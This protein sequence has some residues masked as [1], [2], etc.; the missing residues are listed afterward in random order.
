MTGKRLLIIVTACA[1]LAAGVAVAALPARGSDQDSVTQ[2]ALAKTGSIDCF[3]TFASGTGGSYFAWCYSTYGNIVR[4]ESPAGVE[5]IRV[6]T[7][8]EGYAVCANGGT[9]GWD[10]GNSGGGFNA[11][12]YPAANTVQL[13]TTNGHFRLN[14]TFSQSTK[15]KSVT[16]AMRLTNLTSST[17]SGV[18]L[19]R[20]ADLDINGTPASDR[21]D[22]SRASV[23]ALE[24]NG[25]ALSGTS[26][27]ATKTV[28]VESF[29]DLL[30]DTDCSATTPLATPFAGDGAARV[31]YEMGALVA[32]Q[33]KTQ[34]FRYQLL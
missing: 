1:V 2:D 22:V 12:T 7:F 15:D 14:M 24:T 23:V 3:K 26:P 25:M 32:G 16:V 11:P 34:T 33:S 31:T 18:R 30:N 19:S 6:G 21:W 10:N 8:M 17:L 5:H 4:F 29:G 27:S 9:D 20:F 13:T 28:T